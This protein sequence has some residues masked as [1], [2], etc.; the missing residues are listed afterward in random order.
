MMWYGIVAIL[1]SKQ[2]RYYN[3]Y[4]GNRSATMKMY[5]IGSCCLL[6]RSNTMM[7]F[8]I[9]AMLFGQQV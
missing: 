9:D 5:G 6:S 2:V 1:C 8:V 3:R 7:V 4:F